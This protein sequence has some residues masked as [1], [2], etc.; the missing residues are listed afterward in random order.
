MCNFDEKTART[1][2]NYLLDINLIPVINMLED[3]EYEKKIK[4]IRRMMGELIDELFI[5]QGGWLNYRPD[6]IISKKHIRNNGT[7]DIDRRRA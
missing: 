2:W 6:K 3:T 5:A 4:E 7:S 1:A